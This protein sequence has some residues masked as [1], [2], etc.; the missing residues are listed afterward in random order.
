MHDSI[1]N[2]VSYVLV[3]TFRSSAARVTTTRDFFGR[4]AMNLKYPVGQENFDL[5][6]E[7]SLP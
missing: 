6:I 4:S 2:G 3:T 5:V 7:C 1:T